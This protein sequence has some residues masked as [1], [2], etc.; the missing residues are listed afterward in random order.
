M[1]LNFQNYG[2]EI[3]E[4]LSPRTL[5][6][7]VVPEIHLSDRELHSNVKVSLVT[8]ENYTRMET[9]YYCSKTANNSV[10]Y[11]SHGFH[12]STFVQE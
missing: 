5:S 11:F 12:F 2:D 8:V 6:C 10:I 3:D 1:W 9:G 7:I 4:T